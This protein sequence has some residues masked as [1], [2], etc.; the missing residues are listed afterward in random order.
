MTIYFLSGRAVR[1]GVPQ[2]SLLGPLLFNIYM[3]D[4]NHFV[5]VSSLRLYADDTTA[6]ASDTSPLVLEYIINSD[7]QSVCKWFQN[8]YLNINTTKT[9]AMAIGPVNYEYKINPH[10]SNID[11]NDSLKILGVALDRKMTFKP[12]ILE[13]LKK[14]CAK[15]AALRKLRKFIPHEVM[16]RLY[17]AYILPHLEYCSPLLL[18]ISI[19]LKNKLED[20]NYY[21][22]RNILNYSRAVSY[23]FLLNKAELQ[24]LVNRRK[25]QSLVLL[26]KCLNGQGPQYLS[27]FFKV[28]NVNYNLRGSGTRLVLPHFN[29]EC[30]HKSWSYLTT[31]LWNG[32]PAGVRGSP[33]L[34]VFKRALHSCLT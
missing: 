30:K 33:T 24:N 20:T 14:A 9:Q 22:L 11:L 31:M 29:L 2:G 17:K 25:F 3:N 18:G 19:G 21:I 1:S 27:E 6:Y 15:T 34:A 5:Q 10:N 12:Y 16:I 7:L 28:L 13:Q 4:L 32:L 8:K 23:D 26:F